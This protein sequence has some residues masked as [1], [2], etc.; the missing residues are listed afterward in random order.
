MARFST[1]DI[2]LHIEYVCMLTKWFNTDGCCHKEKLISVFY[3]PVCLLIFSYYFY[4]PQ[5]FPKYIPILQ[6][7]PEDS[8]CSLEG[9]RR[10][11]YFLKF[12]LNL[13]FG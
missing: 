10:K 5:I 13:E 7:L 11:L 9:S 3:F 4:F 1:Q 8:L 2:N 6:A 12:N